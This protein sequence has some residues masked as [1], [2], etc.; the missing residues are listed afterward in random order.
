MSRDTSLANICSMRDCCVKQLHEFAEQQNV[1]KDHC[2]LSHVN[3]D[4]MK[5]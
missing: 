4:Y 2:V 5:N 1:C 3:F